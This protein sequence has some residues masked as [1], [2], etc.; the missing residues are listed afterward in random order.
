[1]SKAKTELYLVV[2]RCSLDDIPCGIYND[3]GRAIS[4]MRR[5]ARNPD[6]VP[7]A[8]LKSWLTDESG[9]ISVSVFQVNL[10]STSIGKI[11][12]STPVRSME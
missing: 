7:K 5:V 9:P 2:L 4:R 6:P 10:N 11:V 3:R 8:A 12:A 1:M